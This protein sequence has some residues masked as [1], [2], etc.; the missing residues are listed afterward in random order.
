[1]TARP[2]PTFIIDTD[3]A[4]TLVPVERRTRTCGRGWCF[5]GACRVD[6]NSYEIHR[7]GVSHGAF[8]YALSQA[9]VSAGPEATY[10][11]VFEQ[12]LSRMSARFRQHPQIEGEGDRWL[13]GAGRS[14]R[15]VSCRSSGGPEPRPLWR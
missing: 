4:G 13:F 15:C 10:R 3:Y 8:T 7:E 12:V 11:Q 14:S 2:Y 5:S 1:M 9:L 6:E